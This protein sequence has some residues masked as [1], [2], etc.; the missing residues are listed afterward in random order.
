MAKGI[1]KAQKAKIWTK[2]SEIGM[3]EKHLRYL[4]RWV[5][6]QE[7]TRELTKL[8][9]ILL[10]D[11]L[12]GKTPSPSPNS[13]QRGTIPPDSIQGEITLRPRKGGKRIG[14][15]LPPA[16]SSQ[17]AFIESLKIEAG[18]DDEHLKNFIRKW[19]KAG[20]I[21]ELDTKQAGKVIEVLKKQK[22]KRM[23]EGTYVIS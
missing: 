11:V 2:A 1:T 6:G 17:I 23:K 12:E 16:S 3:V 8:Q 13:L 22:Q 4:V 21:K 19:Y 10:I 18:Y 15:F 5:S 14:C 7:S 20:S 9:G